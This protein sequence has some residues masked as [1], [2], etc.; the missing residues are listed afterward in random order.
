MMK[1]DYMKVFTKRL[2]TLIYLFSI[3]VFSAS[4]ESKTIDCLPLSVSKH[5]NRVAVKCAHVVNNIK[6]FA[7]S[8]S[9]SYLADKLEKTVTQAKASGGMVEIKYSERDVSG[10][11]FGCLKLNCRRAQSILRSKNHKHYVLNM[12]NVQG[13]SRKALIYYSPK[14]K[15]PGPVLFYFHGR[16]GSM[17]DSVKRRRFHELWPEAIIVYAEGTYVDSTGRPYT[18]KKAAWQLRFPNKYSLGQT[19]DLEYITTILKKLKD[20]HKIDEN[21]VFA[22]GHSSGAFLTL[23]LMELAPD[24]FR[25]YA[26]VGAYARFI[27]EPTSNENIIRN[28]TTVLPTEPDNK[29]K[30]PRPVFYM[31]GEKDK[32]FD[33]DSPDRLPGWNPSVHARSRAMDT[34]KQLFIR[35]SCKQNVEMFEDSYES[36]C[37][38]EANGSDVKWWIYNGGH[39]WPEKA[40]EKVV[41]FF[42]GY[43]S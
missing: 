1:K 5:Q 40:D 20:K 9:Q 11:K 33:N 27:I 23:S 32:V 19:K 7:V 36:S 17:L 41:E 13:E 14:K 8:S 24:I 42:K 18:G 3:V 29:A 28:R 35:N 4:A 31:F 39:S 30:Q 12:D 15:G 38:H 37:T 25:A 26:P 6:Y 43:G 21:R 2:V 10:V 22:A 34:L 16:G